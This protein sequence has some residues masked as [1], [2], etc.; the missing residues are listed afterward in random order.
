[1]KKLFCLVSFLCIIYYLNAQT[2]KIQPGIKGGVNISS[3]EVDG[4]DDLDSR[5][6]FHAGGLVHIHLNNHWAVQP[7]VVFSAQGG[8]SGG[9]KLKLNYI[10]VPILLQFMTNNGFRL[11]TGPQLGFLLSAESKIGDVEVDVDDAFKMLDFAWSFGAGYIFQNGFGLDA[12][13]NLGISNI[14]DNSSTD[15]MNRVFQFGVFYQ[16]KN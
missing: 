11:Q 12:R 5:T 16:F 8:E 6:G 15:A 2:G 9:T 7:E 4:G 14:N 3:I 1:M 13:Y 10:N